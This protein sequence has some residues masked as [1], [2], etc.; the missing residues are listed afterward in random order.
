MIGILCQRIYIN[1]DINLVPE[2]LHKQ[3]DTTTDMGNWRRE[4]IICPRKS[5][6]LLKTIASSRHHSHD[7]VLFMSLLQ[8]F[9]HVPREIYLE[10]LL[11]QD[12]QGDEC[13]NKYAR[14]YKVVWLLDIHGMLGWN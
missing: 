1:D 13:A 10:S 7:A 3:D 11:F 4:G 14:V 2:N 8:V 9:N 6:N 12:Q 5:G